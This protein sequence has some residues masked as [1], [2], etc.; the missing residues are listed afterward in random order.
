VKNPHRIRIMKLLQPLKQ[1]AVWTAPSV[2]ILV[3]ANLVPLAGV[4][5]FGWAVFPIMLLFWLEN[6]IVGALNALKMLL[7]GG[8]APLQAI[9][10]F[11]VPFFCFHYG[12]FTLVHGVFVFAM[13]GG[14]R[15][16]GGGMFPTW[17]YVSST[18]WEQHLIW[19]VVGLVLSHV[20]SFGWNYLYRGEFRRV[21]VDQLMMQPYGRVVVLHVAILGGG[22]L[23]MALGSPVAGLALLIVLKIILD[24]LAHVKQHAL[25]KDRSADL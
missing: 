12:G 24:V 23:I 1:T 15:D 16:S 19:A 14:R 10:L 5:F 3:L 11:L 4:M 6:V 22:F 7:A 13:F 8:P 25:G 9:K 20:F 21:R 18:V 17:D 2:V